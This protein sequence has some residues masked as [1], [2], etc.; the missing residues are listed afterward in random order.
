M[1]NTNANGFHGSDSME[2]NVNKQFWFEMPGWWGRLTNVGRRYKR[3]SWKSRENQLNECVRCDRILEKCKQTLSCSMLWTGFS[4]LRCSSRPTIACDRSH[5]VTMQ[6]IILIFCSRFDDT[7]WM[8]NNGNNRKGFFFSTKLFHSCGYIC[9]APFLL[10]FAALI[11]LDCRLRRM[12]MAQD[13]LLRPLPLRF[14]GICEK[15][16]FCFSTRQLSTRHGFCAGER[17]R[18]YWGNKFFSN[19]LHW[20]LLAV[21]FM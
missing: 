16:I 2:T 15:N 19:S 6:T 3:N 20:L 10:S 7:Q 14:V 18:I 17:V 5:C 8:A 21:C 12:T 4:F 13:F 9:F 1:R 11:P